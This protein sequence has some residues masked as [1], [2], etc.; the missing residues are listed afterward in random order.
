MAIKHS[1]KADLRPLNI[2]V[3]L[4][5]W[6]KDVQNDG[7]PILIIVSDYTLVGVCCI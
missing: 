5:L 2:D 3:C 1:E 4:V 6:L 7:D